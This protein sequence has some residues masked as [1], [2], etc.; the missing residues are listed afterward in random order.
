MLAA[1]LAP[2]QPSAQVRRACDDIEAFMRRASMSA[3][4]GVMAVMDD[5]S[6]KHPVFVHTNDESG[7]PYQPQP[8]TKRKYRDT[9]K[10]NVAAYELAR[11]LQVNIMPPYVEGRVDGKPA[12]I[13]WGLDDVIMD[14]LQRQQRKVQPPDPEAWDRQMHVVRVFD[15][16][17]YDGR[18][19][20]DLL[21]TG[22]WRA[23]IIGPSQ[24]FSPNRTLQNHDS[25][26]RG[27]IADCWPG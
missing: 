4:T 5:G 7:T 11:L 1:C 10:A 22:D 19:P 23:W 21:I 15:E 13:S 25:L 12:S 18:A 16:L 3:L 9:W 2:V 24:G 27:P 14:D 17:I 8:G 26:S 20:S 6:V